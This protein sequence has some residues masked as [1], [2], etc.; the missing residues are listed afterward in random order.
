MIWSAE[1]CLRFGRLA[2]LSAAQSRVQRLE[3]CS[4]GRQLDGDR[5]AH[6]KTWRLIVRTL[7]VYS[8]SKSSTSV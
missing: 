1:T 4:H 3:Q 8:A 5:S 6:S 7:A 2:D